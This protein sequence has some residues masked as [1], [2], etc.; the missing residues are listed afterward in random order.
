MQPEIM[1]RFIAT[2]LCYIRM[3]NFLFTITS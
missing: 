3:L 1:L 2:M